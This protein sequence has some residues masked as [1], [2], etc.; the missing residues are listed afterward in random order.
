M[1]CVFL[2]CKHHKFEMKLTN[3]TVA[4]YARTLKSF[5]LLFMNGMEIANELQNA[6]SVIKASA[7]SVGP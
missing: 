5:I 7:K 4:P 3:P 2:Q 6:K 1:Q